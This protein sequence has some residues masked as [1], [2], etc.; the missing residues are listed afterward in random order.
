LAEGSDRLSE[1]VPYDG[2][3]NRCERWLLIALLMQE[4]S[5][6]RNSG[7]QVGRRSERL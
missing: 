1:M 3:A 4:W 2:A 6:G 7:G 5:R